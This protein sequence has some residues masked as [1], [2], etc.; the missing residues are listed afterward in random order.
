M[1][2]HKMTFEEIK[3]LHQC[4]GYCYGGVKYEA[5]GNEIDIPMCQAIDTCEA[6]RTGEGIAT[7]ICLLFFL[8]WNLAILI[9]G[10]TGIF[11]IVRWLIT[12]L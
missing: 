4:D 6:T 5:E 10:V 8:L 7:L 2:K 9:L 1:K 11:C 12:W 3:E